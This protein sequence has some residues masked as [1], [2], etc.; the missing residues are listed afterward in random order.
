MGDFY[1]YLFATTFYF[2]RLRFAFA[3]LNGTSTMPAKTMSYTLAQNKQQ[4]TLNM[5]VRRKIDVIRKLDHVSRFAVSLI[6]A[7]LCLSTQHVQ[8][9][10]VL[11]TH[12]PYLYAGDAYP[13]IEYIL[14]HNAESEMM[15]EGKNLPSFLYNTDQGY[16][17]V[18]FYSSR[19]EPIA[20]RLRDSYIQIAYSTSQ[21]V[22]EQNPVVTLDAYAVCCSTVPSLC[23]KQ[24]I[25]HMALREY[26]PAFMM[27]KPGSS[28]GIQMEKFNAST[29]LDFMEISTPDM[30]ID[31]MGHNTHIDLTE[32]SDGKDVHVRTIEELKADIHLSLYTF[33][34]DHIFV[35][36]DEHENLAPLSI[37]KRAALKK[38]LLLIQ[39]SLP[40][41]WPVHSMVRA[42]I[43]SFMYVCRNRAYL[44]TAL[45]GHPPERTEFS[46]SCPIDKVHVSG[47]TCGTWEMI[48]AIT[49][50]VVERNKMI[51]STT[52]VQTHVPKNLTTKQVFTSIDEAAT[53][54]RNFV[55]YFG[56]GD[57][58]NESQQLIHSLDACKN[59]HC[60]STNNTSI[61][62]IAQWIKLPLY[63][64][65]LHGTITLKKQQDISKKNQHA[66]TTFEQH[67][68]SMWPPKYACPQ[69]WDE[70]GKWDTN[71]VYKYMQLEY[72]DLNEWSLSS[73]EIRQELLGTKDI[74]ASQQRQLGSNPYS[75]SNIKSTSGNYI[76]LIMQQIV[77]LVSALGIVF[78]RVITFQQQKQQEATLVLPQTIWTKA[79]VHRNRSLKQNDW[80][81]YAFD[82]KKS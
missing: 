18:E 5:R 8:A 79:K 52:E 78:Y 31:S 30:Q 45:D 48:H 32:L 21:V 11:R 3:M 61:S 37:E 38:Y 26:A 15:T 17:I 54:L 29:I 43:D 64:S 73:P 2:K 56:L 41:S 12:S 58:D 7:G 76:V 19:N 25:D 50:G 47:L 9:S 10:N 22:K 63:F 66:M 27:Y 69:C 77:V 4:A 44:L 42:L 62:P 28:V 71:V 6:V 23:E 34:R 1:D 33:I 80:L 24:G 36:H 59:D 57:D 60:L 67:M 81:S 20:L 75:N 51:L 74:L 39:K 40:S 14:S 35:D 49:V 16:R 70:H 13:V 46:P 65:K 72:T 68:I 53:V 82:H 55:H